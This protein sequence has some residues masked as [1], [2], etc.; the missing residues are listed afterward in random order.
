MTVDEFTTCLQ[1]VSKYSSY[2]FDVETCI[3]CFQYMYCNYTMQLLN[4]DD[5]S[6]QSLLARVAKLERQII[7]LTNKIDGI[8]N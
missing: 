3:L 5:Y 6:T 1:S 7:I 2:T 8:I 4:N